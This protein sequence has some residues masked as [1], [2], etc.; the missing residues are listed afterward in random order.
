MSDE[1]HYTVLGIPE[2]ATQDEIKRAYRELIRQV[3][4][5]HVPNASPYWKR[6][7]EEKSKELNEAYHVLID[8][9]RRRSYD[10]QL[11]SHRGRFVPG[12]RCNSAAPLE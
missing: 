2:G 9:K 1:T 4:P 8:P 7:A 6:A 3:H 5:D 11:A 12:R 10:E